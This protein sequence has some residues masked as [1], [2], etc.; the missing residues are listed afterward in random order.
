MKPK[1]Y[2]G[3]LEWICDR[4]GHEFLVEIER[5]FI[6]NKFNLIGLEDKFKQETNC[7]QS[8]WVVAKHIFKS[9]CPTP[10]ALADEKYTEFL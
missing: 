2:D 5:G 1:R 9:K 4:P 6:K 7:Q 3:L 10:Q 8:I